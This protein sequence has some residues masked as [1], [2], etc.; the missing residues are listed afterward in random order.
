M[1]LDLAISPLHALVFALLGIIA[2]WL[3][4]KICC[5]WRWT[6]LFF[7]ILMIVYSCVQRS[8]LDGSMQAVSTF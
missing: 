8:Y 1:N 3:L 2:F 5:A 6:M 7:G 4:S